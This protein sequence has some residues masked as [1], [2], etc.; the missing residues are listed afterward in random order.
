MILLSPSSRGRT[1]DVL[2]GGFG[3]DVEVIDSAL[4]RVFERCPVDPSR[5]AVGGFSDGASYA[6]S[7][8]LTNGDLFTHV[9]ALSP[10]FAAPTELRGSPRLFVS[11]G[12]GDRVLPI[13]STSRRVVP[14]MERQGYDV[15]YEEFDGGHAV[16]PRIAR[17]AVHWFLDAAD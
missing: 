6:L 1:W 8:G 10:G 13:R 15:R 9:I 12:V 11:H 17:E 4:T 5:L 2:L 16:P 14:I 3:P 7:V